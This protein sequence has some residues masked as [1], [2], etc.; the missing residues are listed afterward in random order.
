MNRFRIAFLS[1]VLAVLLAP[2]ASA[3]LSRPLTDRQMEAFRWRSVGPTNMMGRITDVEGVP[4]PSRTVYVA[5][6]AGGVWKTTNNGTTFELIWDGNGR[7]VSMGDIGLAPSDP[8]VLY[9]GT[10]EEDSRNS[11]SPG[12]GVFKSTDGGETWEAV[13]LEG[14]QAIGRIAVHPEDPDVAFVAALGHIWGSNPD[15]G[16]YRTR[17]G[18]A[19]WQLVKFISDRAGFV[20]VLLDP[21]DPDVVW[22]A[23][24]ERV[25]G[26]YF[27]QSGG[28]GSGLWKSTDGGDSWTE[29]AGDGFPTAMKGRIGLAIAPSDPDVMYA[30]VEAEEG[31]GLYRSADGGRTWEKKNDVNTRPFYYS[32]VRVDPAD[33][34]RVYFSSTPVQFSDDGGETY[35]TTT[36]DVHV[37]HHAMWIDPTDPQRV[38]VGNDGGV[39]FSFDR[40][41]NW[42]VPNVIALGQFYDVSYNMDVPYR[43]CG[44]LQ[45]NGTWCG[46]SRLAG[47]DITPYHW[48]SISGGDGFVSAQDPEDPDLIWSESQ[49]G[50]IGRGNLATGERTSLEK[51]DWED[52]WRPKQDTI[53]MLLEGGAEEDDAR[54]RRLRA[55]A[56]RDSADAVMRYNWNTPFFQSVHDRSWFYAAGN[57][58]LKSEHRGDSLRIIS[59]DLSYADP[60]KIRI[61]T[62]STGGITPDV[63]G[64]ETFATITALE[65]S[66]LRAG[67][68][69]AGTDDGRV[70]STRDDGA[71]WTE[72]TSRI[73]GVPEGTYVSRITASHHAPDRVYV[74]FDNHRRNDFTP[75]AFVSDDG[76][77]T[78]RSVA[79]DLP[80]GGVDFLHVITEDPHNENLLFVGSDVGAYVSTDR[81]GSWQRFGVGLPTVP[82]HD[83]EIH[84]RD[85]ELIA[86]THGRSIWIVGIAALEGLTDAVVADGAALFEPAPG[87]Q[88]GSAARGGESTGQMAFSR[89]TPGSN[90]HV[91]YY[92]G[93]EL[94]AALADAAD[95][96]EA[97]G[98]GGQGAG[99]R[100][101]GPQATLVVRSPDGSV[102]RTLTGSAGAGLHR[103]DWNFRGE[104]P[105]R[106]EPSPSERRDRDRIATRAVEVRDSLVEAGWDEQ[107]LDRMVGFLTGEVDRQQMF[108][109]FGGGGGGGQRGGDPE[110]FRDR[111]GESTGGGGGFDFGRMRTLADLVTPGGGLGALFRGGG[112]APAPLAEPGTYTVSLEIGD[113]TFTRDLVV[114]RH[115]DLGGVTDPFEAEWAAFL[116]RIERAR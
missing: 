66:P 1:A 25:R 107:F 57:R 33:A 56:T 49:G 55:E 17:D 62:D 43:V 111:P 4:G 78:F 21:R 35:G 93:E 94:A 104:S 105:P 39:A 82:V 37:D 29:V 58:V 45:D 36:N 83:L 108:A 34:D 97:D 72:L 98:N 87:L 20:D 13:G 84:P 30:M 12:G 53:V 74:T 59:P 42:M 31:N 5:A 44:G 14:T 101:R 106:A 115:G 86:G 92:V 79:A 7:V 38:V 48:A 110:A 88:F 16:L 91:H 70:W 99:R 109:F 85:R 95:A 26:P 46:P 89:P 77:G 32:Q 15:R 54:I 18:G 64:A 90:A 102:F 41:G 24:W 3:Q 96:A 69:F 114:E 71:T 47:D 80:T 112:G 6:A 81:G 9:L 40:G 51:P 27:L 52:A 60:L 100:A 22:A 76:G 67:W 113:R 50:N 116:R 68:L 103:V 10:G 23:S 61:S 65:E 63:T 2:A 28:P 75:Y 19:S 73:R 8:D 11:I